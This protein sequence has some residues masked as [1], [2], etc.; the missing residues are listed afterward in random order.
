MILRPKSSRDDLGV[1]NDGYGLI[2]KGFL[3]GT[4]DLEVVEDLALFALS[5]SRIDRFITIEG[6]EERCHALLS[7]KEKFIGFRVPC[8]CALYNSRLEMGHTS[9]LQSEKSTNGKA[10]SD[11]RD[12]DCD[13]VLVPD[14]PALEIREL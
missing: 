12:E 4:F 2:G 14:P 11:G 7:I 1:I 13:S 5:R 8:L 3:K 6:L 10:P 9:S